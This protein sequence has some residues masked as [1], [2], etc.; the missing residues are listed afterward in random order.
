MV[1]NNDLR[2]RLVGCVY[3]AIVGDLF[4]G[5]DQKTMQPIISDTFSLD[6]QDFI[7]YMNEYAGGAYPV[8]EYGG[9]GV[10]TLL[11]DMLVFKRS[12]LNS[13]LGKHTGRFYQQPYLAACQAIYDTV[14]MNQGRTTWIRLNGPQNGSEGLTGLCDEWN[15]AVA[16]A[17][18]SYAFP[19][20]LVL[21]Q[22]A[23][24]RGATV[25]MLAGARFGLHSIPGKWLSAV[26]VEIKGIVGKFV[27]MAL[28]SDKKAS[29]VC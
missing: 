18:E 8:V 22:N 20:S 17:R 1:E 11:P 15:V 5:V 24:C 10:V 13:A 7:R 9:K 6:V 21:A 3:G 14:F 4:R 2:D 23:E 25:G 26:P 28:D 27:N 19:D 16:L 12:M 29:E